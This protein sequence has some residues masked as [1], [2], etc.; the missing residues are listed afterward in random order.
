MERIL[1]EDAAVG[2]KTCLHL[3]H[4]RED[5]ETG[6]TLLIQLNE[7][8]NQKHQEEKEEEEKKKQTSNVKQKDLKSIKVDK[9]TRKY[10]LNDEDEDSYSDEDD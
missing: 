1:P 6:K 3:P 2:D 10:D 9:V 5:R 7:V 4:I 8:A